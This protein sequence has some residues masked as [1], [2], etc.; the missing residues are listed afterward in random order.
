MNKKQKCDYEES[1]ECE[2]NNEYN[3]KKNKKCEINENYKCNNEISV[4]YQFFLF[5]QLKLLMN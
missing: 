5:I 3:C 1:R 2:Q 4:N